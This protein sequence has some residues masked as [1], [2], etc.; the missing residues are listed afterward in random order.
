MQ[1][2]FDAFWR[3]SSGAPFGLGGPTSSPWVLSQAGPFTEYSIAEESTMRSHV[4]N[5]SQVDVVPTLCLAPA[6]TRHPPSASTPSKSAQ[7]SPPRRSS[8]STTSKSV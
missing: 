5:L 6:S 7:S 3:A 2:V 4:R 1:G 8:S